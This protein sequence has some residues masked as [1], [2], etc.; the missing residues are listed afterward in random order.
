MV[1]DVVQEFFDHAVANKTRMQIAEDLA[2][3]AAGVGA[4]KEAV[5]GLLSL[6]LDCGPN[7]ASNIA[8]VS[9][10]QISA[11]SHWTVLKV[12]KVKR[13]EQYYLVQFSTDLAGI[14]ISDNI[15]ISKVLER[16]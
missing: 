6:A 4:S 11:P 15:F 2:D 12:N 13:L 8:T 5:L 3:M 14:Q 16:I 1:N 7:P 10:P 9:G